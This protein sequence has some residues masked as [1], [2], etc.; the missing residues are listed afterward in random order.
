MKNIKK[1]QLLFNVLRI[2][3]LIF[4]IKNLNVTKNH[5]LNSCKKQQNNY[6]F[7]IKTIY[8]N[9]INYSRVFLRYLSSTHLQ[10]TTFQISFK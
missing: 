2:Y 10:L 8:H 4:F 5:L 1:Y 7:P 6:V 3:I 9:L